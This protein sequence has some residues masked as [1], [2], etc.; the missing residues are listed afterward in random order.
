MLKWSPSRRL[1]V[2]VERCEIRDDGNPIPCVLITRKLQETLVDGGPAGVVRLVQRHQS[3]VRR[4]CRNV[5]ILEPD[6]V[7]ALAFVLRPLEFV[8]VPSRI[9]V[10]GSGERDLE[11]MLSAIEVVD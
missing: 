8:D 5:V 10:G 2:D 1:F 11:P 6:Q 4:Q 7:R 3:S 9:L